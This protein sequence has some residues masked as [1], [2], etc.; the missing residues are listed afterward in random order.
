MNNER[1]AIQFDEDAER[2]PRTERSETKTS[3]HES[4]DR[5]PQIRVNC[6][7]IT[8]RE[9]LERLLRE[10]ENGLMSS[11]SSVEESERPELDNLGRVGGRRA[12]AESID[13]RSEERESKLVDG[14]G[15]G[16]GLLPPGRGEVG[17]ELWAR[18]KKRRDGSGRV[19]ER[20]REAK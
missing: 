10:V 7:L 5:T 20:G 6:L 3:T 16:L 12:V 15:D 2:D 17:E 19:D 13:E 14:L 8:S 11:D 18:E 4:E 9:L 1:K